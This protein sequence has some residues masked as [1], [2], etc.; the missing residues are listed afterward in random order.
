MPDNEQDELEPEHQSLPPD[1]QALLRQGRKAQR[2]AANAQ[3]ELAHVQ[4]MKAVTEAGFPSSPMTE[5]V[6]K[7]YEGPLD[8]EAI[9]ARANE[10]GLTI[11]VPS[12]PSSG[13]S[14][15][16]EAAQRAILNATGGAPA[17][18]G[19]VDLAV[20]FRNA[21]SQSEVMAIVTEVAGTP[22][23]RSRDGLIGVLPEPI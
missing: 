8:A 1:V 14:A 9:R 7:D 13:V 20:A 3:A 18:S 6:F 5:L 12:E 10:V 2:D 23:F 19:D 4:R 21:K 17:A 16:E 15:E 11:P 22:G